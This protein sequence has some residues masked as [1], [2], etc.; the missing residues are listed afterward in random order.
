[1]FTLSLPGCPGHE[2]VVCTPLTPGCPNVEPVPPPHAPRSCPRDARPRVSVSRSAKLTRSSGFPEN[3]AGSIHGPRSHEARSTSRLPAR[4]P[5]PH[6]TGRPYSE[7]DLQARLPEPKLSTSCVGRPHHEIS[8]VTSVARRNDFDLTARGTRAS[9]CLPTQFPRRT[10]R[11]D[12]TRHPNSRAT[13]PPGFPSGEAA[14]AARVA[15]TL[16]P[17]S[18]P[19]SPAASTLAPSHRL[20]EPWNLRRRS[21]ARSTPWLHCADPEVKPAP[22]HGC[23]HDDSD[24]TARM[25]MLEAL[26][27]RSFPR[28]AFPRHTVTCVASGSRCDVL[29]A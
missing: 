29:T 2:F 20:L 3:R 17:T 23:P 8:A 9:S 27:S 4:S 15:C 24:L 26:A 14:P 10:S 19:R 25:P 28:E 16:K 6:C 13:A 12:R 1:V 7:V 18:L 22:S 11:I 21:V 5:E